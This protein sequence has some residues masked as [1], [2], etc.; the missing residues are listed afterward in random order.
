MQFNTVNSKER[1]TALLFCQRC[2]AFWSVSMLQSRCSMFQWL[3]FCCLVPYRPL[4]FYSGD[5]T[6]WT[7]SRGAFHFTFPCGGVGVGHVRRLPV[8]GVAPSL[9]IPDK[10]PSHSYVSVNRVLWLTIYAAT[11]DF[12]AVRKA[13][14]LNTILGLWFVQDKTMVHKFAHKM[15]SNSKYVIPE[16]EICTN[17]KIC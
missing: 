5:R 4:P 10:Q 7:S 14:F 12:T 11:V 9:S 1:V 13:G 17:N 16:I 6:N 8:M 3:C 15:G 2:W